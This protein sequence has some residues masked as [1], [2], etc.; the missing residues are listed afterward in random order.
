MDVAQVAATAAAAEV[1]M[2][3]ML[4]LS[5]MVLIDRDVRDRDRDGGDENVMVT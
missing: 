4:V 3:A 2:V 5:L 1:A